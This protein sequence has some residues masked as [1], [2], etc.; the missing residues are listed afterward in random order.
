MLKTFSALALTACFGVV[1]VIGCGDDDKDSGTGLPPR[2]SGDKDG[3]QTNTSSSGGN[4]SSSGD[5]TYDCTNHAAVDPNPACDQCARSKCC[6]QIT[7]CDQTP[8]CKTAQD[9]LAACASDDFVCI[10]GCSATGG[11]GGEILN[12]FG[13][14]LVN[15]CKSECSGSQPE[16]DAGFDA[17]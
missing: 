1:L 12:E 6:E 3:G 10:T 17:F 7:Q 9:C 5:P 14:C 13:A 16:V 11:K 2:N 4:T 8:S 15:G